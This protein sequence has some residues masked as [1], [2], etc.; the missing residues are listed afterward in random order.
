MTMPSKPPSNWLLT[1][2]VALIV[3]AAIT[4]VIVTLSSA[5]MPL[6]IAVGVIGI[7]ARLVF[8]H[9]RRW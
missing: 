7:T 1:V 5:L 3:L 4:P 6:V 9:T 8:H 2:I